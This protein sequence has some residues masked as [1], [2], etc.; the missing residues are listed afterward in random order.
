LLLLYRAPKSTVGDVE[1]LHRVR[2]PN[3]SGAGAVHTAILSAWTSFGQITKG[4]DDT[5]KGMTTR[6]RPLAEEMSNRTSKSTGYCLE[7]LF[8]DDRDRGESD[9]GQQSKGLPST[10][11][12]GPKNQ[13]IPALA[14]GMCFDLRRPRVLLQS[15]ASQRYA[16][17]GSA[18]VRPGVW[19]VGYNKYR[20]TTSRWAIRDNGLP[21]SL[22]HRM[23]IVCWA[24][25]AL[26]L[27]RDYLNWVR[28]NQSSSLQQELIKKSVPIKPY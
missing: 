28:P 5:Q 17:V 7:R 4:Q 25:A 26:L 1:Q 23:K 3:R 8:L 2:R 19:V 15:S 9:Q 20:S 24:V 27:R 16:H 12:C 6:V 18:P 11:H 13:F 14:G 21:S 22:A 10:C